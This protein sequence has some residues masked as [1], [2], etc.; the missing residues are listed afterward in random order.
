MLLNIAKNAAKK[1]LQFQIQYWN[2]KLIATSKAI[3]KKHCQYH[4]LNIN[5]PEYLNIW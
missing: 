2:K 3:L 1:V 5:N 4:Y